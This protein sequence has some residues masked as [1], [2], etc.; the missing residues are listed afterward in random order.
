MT[1]LQLTGDKY[2]IALVSEMADVHHDRSLKRGY[3]DNVYD[4]E[5]PKPGPSLRP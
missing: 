4:C 1:Q 3:I 5:S 2:N